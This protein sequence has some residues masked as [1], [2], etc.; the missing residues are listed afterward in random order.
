MKTA[1]TATTAMMM[2]MMSKRRRLAITLILVSFS[3]RMNYDGIT[4]AKILLIIV[5]IAFLEFGIMDYIYFYDI[6]L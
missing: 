1:T 3:F 5:I 4:I 2:A 6:G